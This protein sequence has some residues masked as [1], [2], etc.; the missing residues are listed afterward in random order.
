M[1]SMDDYKQILNAIEEDLC[2]VC[3]FILEVGKLKAV[4]RQ[5]YLNDADR[6]ENSAEHSW[7]L[8]VMAMALRE[9]SNQDIDLFKTIKMLIVH[10][11]GEIDGGDTFHYD[12]GAEKSSERECLIRILSQAPETMAQEMLNLWDEFDN[13]DTQE[14]RFAR[15]LDRFHPFLQLI[16]NGGESWKRNK[17]SYQKALSKNVH[18]NDGSTFLWDAYQAMARE[19]DSLGYFYR[20][21]ESCAVL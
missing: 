10:D 6:F 9:Y 18:I 3:E 8:I 14:A 13:G 16:Q 19:A 2:E 5:T 17:I 7:H 15:A 4:Q 1:S 11:I 12:K 20:E 21:E